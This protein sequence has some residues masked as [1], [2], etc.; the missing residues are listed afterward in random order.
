MNSTHSL[1]E[2]LQVGEPL[3]HGNL[4]MFPLFS[5]RD[6][7][8]DYLTLDEAMATYKCRIREVTEG[9]SVPELTF[10]NLSDEKILLLDGEELVGA[11]QRVAQRHDGILSS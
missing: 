9:G 7:T 11:K 4:A 3:R 1:I 8:P 10:E 2:G 5:E 6:A